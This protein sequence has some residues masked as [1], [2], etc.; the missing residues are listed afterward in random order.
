LV[1]EPL[2]LVT[3]GGESEGIKTSAL[4]SQRGNSENSVQ[5]QTRRQP[6]SDAVG[7]N[8][9]RG[10]GGREPT[11]GDSAETGFVREGGETQGGR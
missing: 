8:M 6:P 9:G 4:M 7:R 5:I 3:S 11:V 1:G 10:E 2:I